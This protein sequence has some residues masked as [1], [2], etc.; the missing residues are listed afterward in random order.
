MTHFALAFA[1][2]HPTVTW[3]ILGPRTIDQLTD[4]MAAADMALDD[5][6]LMKSTRSSRRES[7]SAALTSTTTRPP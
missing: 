7:I 1:A 6:V 4:Q 2:T 5:D 3:V